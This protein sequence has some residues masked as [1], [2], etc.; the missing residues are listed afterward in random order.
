M[1]FLM[2]ILEDG[3]KCQCARKELQCCE[4][5]LPLEKLYQPRP[6]GSLLSAFLYDMGGENSNDGSRSYTPLTEPAVGEESRFG[7]WAVL[8]V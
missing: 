2:W 5:K 6:H 7:V 8:G 3:Y 4:L 1:M